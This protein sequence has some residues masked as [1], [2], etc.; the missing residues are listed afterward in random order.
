MILAKKN[1]NHSEKKR[2]KMCDFIKEVQLRNSHRVYECGD[3]YK[4]EQVK[5]GRE[6]ITYSQTIPRQAIE[7]EVLVVLVALGRAVLT[8]EGRT[9]FY[10]INR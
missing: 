2:E 3:S 8:K 7:Y 10:R 1:A 9:Y 5:L 4:V 6:Q